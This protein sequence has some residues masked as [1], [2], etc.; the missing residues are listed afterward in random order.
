MRSLAEDIR[1]RTD[2]ELTRLLTAR[3]DLTR[4]APTDLT[5][6]AAR[7]ATVASTTRAI[8][9]L[10]DDHLAALEAMVLL[11]GSPR[12]QLDEV[13]EPVPSGL[14][15]LLGADEGI[16]GRLVALRDAALLWR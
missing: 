6:L 14:A 7:A 10:D 15:G 12:E 9:H 4:P 2:G 3:P 16:A 11:D 1:S 13:E 5:A 8:D